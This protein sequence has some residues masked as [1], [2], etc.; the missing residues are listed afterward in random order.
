[1]PL[2]PLQA[3]TRQAL[4]RPEGTAFI[5]YDDVWTY[6]RRVEESERVAHGLVANV[7]KPGDRVALHM[8]NRPKMMVAYYACYRMGA[9]AAPLRSAFTFA[10]LGPCC[11]AAGRPLYRRNRSLSE[12]RARR[13]CDP[14]PLRRI[15][16][17]DHAGTHGVRAWDVLRQAPPV[18]LP[19]P[20]IREPAVLINTSGTTSRPPSAAL[21]HYRVEPWACG[22]NMVL[23]QMR[24][25]QR[26]RGL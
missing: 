14:S 8:L 12:R 20:S 16:V 23:L 3:L 11:R 9:I 5:F 18:N 22:S 19:S 6:R 15:P 17:D 24:T 10:E 1:M 26:V 2:T 4:S 13:C 21:R 25:Q 7:V